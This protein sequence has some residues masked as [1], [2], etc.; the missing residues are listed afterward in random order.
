MFPFKKKFIFYKKN[1]ESFNI[2]EINANNVKAAKVIV[3]RFSET[4]GRP[5]S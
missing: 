1:S 3:V 5:K 4:H 2:I